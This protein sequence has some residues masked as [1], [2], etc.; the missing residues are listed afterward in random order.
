MH[1]LRFA[2]LPLV[3]CAAQWRGQPSSSLSPSPSLLLV[4]RSLAAS[5]RVTAAFQ[6]GRHHAHLGRGPSCCGS[7]PSLAFLTE[8]LA[9]AQLKSR[10]LQRLGGVRP[11]AAVCR[12]SLKDV[13]ELTPC[14]MNVD[15][16]EERSLA[17][18]PPPFSTHGSRW[19]IQI[20]LAGRSNGLCSPAKLGPA[21]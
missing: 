19:L 14:D 20:C 15:Q 8:V 4:P 7:T 13:G 3:P 1:F 21:Q 18:H 6:R 9:P 5:P 16:Q 2:R 10:A 12:A 11:P 17:G